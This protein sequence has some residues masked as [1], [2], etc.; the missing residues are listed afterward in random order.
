MRFNDLF[1]Y[2]EVDNAIVDLLIV[3][4]AEGIDTIS[5][6]ALIAELESQGHDVD[7][8]SL[9][10]ELQNI[11]MVHNIKNGIVSFHTS[12]KNANIQNVEDPEKDEKVIDKMARKKVKK[13]LSK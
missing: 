1:E 2:S 12:S 4:S 9:F 13:E 11:Q 7:E 6:E 8:P 3:L 10:D 5:M